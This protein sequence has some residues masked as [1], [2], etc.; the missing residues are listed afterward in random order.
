MISPIASRRWRPAAAATCALIAVQGAYLAVL[1]GTWVRAGLTAALQARIDHR[2][3]AGS[4][5]LA[6][7]LLA[8]LV[9]IAGILVVGLALCV[10]RRAP[11]ALGLAF[12][13]EVVWV[14]GYTASLFGG[15]RWTSIL[16]IGVAVAILAG[17]VVN[18]AGQDARP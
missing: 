2:A 10:W 16:S 3:T 14:V 6:V 5:A 12:A 13:F 4:L 18:G 8:T 9:V 11:W 1:A 7:A 15:S 17:L